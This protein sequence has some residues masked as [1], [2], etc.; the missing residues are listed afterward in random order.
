MTVYFRHLSMYKVHRDLIALC[1]LS[2]Y[3]RKEKSPLP[4]AEF[5]IPISVILLCEIILGILLSTFIVCV[6]LMD[7]VKGIRPSP[8]YQILLSLGFSNICHPYLSGLE[9]FGTI[10]FPWIDSVTYFNIVNILDAIVLL[11]SSWL[12]ALLCLFYAVKILPFKSG[13]LGQLKKN[14]NSKVPSLILA[15]LSISLL[16]S[17]SVIWVFDDFF[18]KNNKTS[19]IANIS[20]EGNMIQT[21]PQ[22]FDLAL[23]ISIV[24]PFLIVTTTTVSIVWFLSMHTLH[25]K[26]NDGM[27]DGSVLKVHRK[28]ARTMR[29]LFFLY[30]IYFT[31]EVLI[32]FN[33]LT[34]MSTEYMGTV[35]VLGAYSPIQS[36]ILIS[37]NT[38]LSQ[39]SVRLYHYMLRKNIK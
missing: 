5:G 8:C 26:Q 1:V 25:L 34:K 19:A 13:L 35:I 18:P 3:E 30:V 22:I 38:R 32:V 29:L 7:W 23:I 33:A 37:R 24:F 6:I 15:T 4:M 12:T 2:A 14:I 31:A 17:L 36:F 10:M 27:N 16:N 20:T 39:S 21:N 28:A 11:S 9:D